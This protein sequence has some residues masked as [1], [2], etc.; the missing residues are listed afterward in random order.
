MISIYRSFKTSL[1]GLAHGSRFGTWGR[2]AT[3]DRLMKGTTRIIR[4]D[5]VGICGSSRS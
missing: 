2:L 5:R 4:S 3:V 1:M